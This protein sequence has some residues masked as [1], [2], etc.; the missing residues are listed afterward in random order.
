M[1]CISVIFT[2]AFQIGEESD[3]TVQNGLPV[4]N[5]IHNTNVHLCNETQN[6]YWCSYM[7]FLIFSK[8]VKY[9]L[10]SKLLIDFLAFFENCK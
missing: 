1:Q 6:S 4:P 10:W 8:S 5:L 2:N 7:P 9:L 3:L